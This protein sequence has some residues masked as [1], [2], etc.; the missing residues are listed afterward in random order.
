M[1]DPKPLQEPVDNQR[2]NP[3][4]QKMVNDILDILKA[5]EVTFDEVHKILHHVSVLVSNCKIT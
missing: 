4:Y 3:A 5:N 2:Q 1:F